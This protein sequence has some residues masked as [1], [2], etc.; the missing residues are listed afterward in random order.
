M[1][2]DRSLQNISG[3]LVQNINKQQEIAYKTFPW[4]A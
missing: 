2:Y 3:A 4:H 1:N